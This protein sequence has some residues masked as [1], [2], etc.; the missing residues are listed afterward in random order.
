MTIFD[1][2]IAT[3]LLQQLKKTFKEAY[4]RSEP[5]EITGGGMKIPPKKILQVV[6]QRKNTFMQHAEEVTC[7]VYN[8]GIPNNKYISVFIVGKICA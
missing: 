2:I 5:L 3:C 8:V 1:F 6:V 7:N 4:F